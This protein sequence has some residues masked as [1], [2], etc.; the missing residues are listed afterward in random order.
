MSVEE[1][2]TR[3]RALYWEELKQ[4]KAK[5]IC[6]RLYRNEMNFYVK[7]TDSILAIASSA[8]IGGW[9]IWNKYSFTWS[10]IIASSQV[11]TTLKG[12]FT[13]SKMHKS[14]SA[15]TISFETL[16][17]D[18]EDDWEKISLRENIPSEIVDK[19]TSLRKLQLA[20]EQKFF[21]EGFKPRDKMVAKASLEA[22]CYF[23]ETY[24][25]L[26]SLPTTESNEE[27]PNV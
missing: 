4:L 23:S 18:A 16:Y 2:I 27:T 25:D 10:I 13:F 12:V 11:I 15:L 24:G 21:P 22:E 17:I 5:S 6:I 14:A 8:S 3:Q 9:A 20:A 26:D 7:L 1:Q 19:R